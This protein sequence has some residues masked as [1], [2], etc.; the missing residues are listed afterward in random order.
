MSQNHKYMHVHEE[1]TVYSCSRHADLS[2]SRSSTDGV[3][4]AVTTKNV[5]VLSE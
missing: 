2:A 4:V 1:S 5:G 3:A